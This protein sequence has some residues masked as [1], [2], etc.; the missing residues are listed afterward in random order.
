MY[1]HFEN[2]KY[3]Y[4]K[5]VSVQIPN[6]IFKDLSQSI[7]NKNNS[8]NIQ[9][10]SF[11]YAYLVLVSILYK[12]SHFVDLDNETY[13]Q[14]ADIKE[15]LGYNR[16]T[17]TIDHVIKKDGILDQIGLTSTSRNFPVE[18]VISTTESISD[19]PL[20][21]FVTVEE[22]DKE[23]L[24]YKLVRS[25]VK[26]R[27]YTIKEPL[28]LFEYNEGMGTLY[29]YGNT[30][31]VKLDEILRFMFDEKLD[32]IDFIMY[33][34]FKSKC[35]GN[36]NKMKSLALNVISFELGIGNDA[37]YSHLKKLKDLGFIDVTHKGWVM[38]KDVNHLESN[39]Y[40]FKGI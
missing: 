26:N 14:N 9:Q 25:I 13:I 4:G 37:F 21:E 24:T 33:C 10:S 36:K 39:E 2:L 31:K 20:K 12:Y 19:I 30:H 34:F 38:G 1:K 35:Y 6:E 7:K 29:E 16:I 8:T 22:L 5:D 18:T 23:G 32:N 17:K 28:F 15:L 27:N 40:Y 11:A 3:L